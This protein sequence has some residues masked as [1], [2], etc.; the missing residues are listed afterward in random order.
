MR[1]IKMKREKPTRESPPTTPPRIGPR[2]G[3]EEEL[4]PGVIPEPEPEPLEPAF[5]DDME[6]DDRDTLVTY[7]LVRAR[8]VTELLPRYVTTRECCV[9]VRL[10]ILKKTW[11][12]S[13]DVAVGERPLSWKE[14]GAPP[15]MVYWAKAALCG[16]SVGMKPIQLRDVPV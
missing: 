15:S 10:G 1:K 7:K 3:K 13:V 11:L 5:E 12:Y 6:V 4:G 9:G 2:W 8:G 16:N 14:T